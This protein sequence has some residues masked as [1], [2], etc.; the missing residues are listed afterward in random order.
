MDRPVITFLSDFGADG[1]AA[2]CRGVMLGIARD[3][4]L[5]DISHAVR[6]F[7]V[8]DGAYL[9]WTA[10]PWMPVGVHVA[11]VDPGVGTERLPIAI[12]AARG[13]VLIGPDNGLLVPAAERL[14]GITQARA[15]R[16]PDLLLPGGSATFHG[17]DVFAPAAAHVAIG[18]GFDT[19][20]PVLDP[21]ELVRVPFPEARVEAG[22]LETA[23]LYVDSFGN[24]RLAGTPDD[25]A[26]AVGRLAAG[27]PL[28]LTFSDGGTSRAETAT[29][30]TTFGGVAP[31]TALVYRDSSG[32]I[33]FADNQGNAAARLGARN[34]TPVTIERA[35]PAGRP[36]DRPSLAPRSS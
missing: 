24:L 17:R 35:V 11:V 8:R 27:E 30:E 13:D 25:L 22:R 21:A 7:A 18:A 29:W 32:N 19:V 34:D 1:A 28:R 26:R 4:Q 9:L 16:N 14:G 23:V 5:I 2:I 36:G 20:G 12:H 6:K 15:I 33:A 10:L 31:G 3:A